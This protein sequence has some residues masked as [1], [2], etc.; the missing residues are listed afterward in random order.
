MMS[1]YK[2]HLMKDLNTWFK[3]L[4][5]LA[6]T[7]DNDSS[8]PK[9]ELLLTNGRSIS[10]IIVESQQRKKSHLLMIAN[11]T[12]HY[13]EPNITIIKSSQIAGLTFIEPQ[14][15]PRLFTSNNVD[16]TQLTG[17]LQFKR[18]VKDAAEE[19]NNIIP[20]PI[21][22]L[23][24][25]DSYLET[26]RHIVLNSLKLIPAVFKEL[27]ADELGKSLV[28]E[29]IKTIKISIGSANTATLNDQNLELIIKNTSFISSSEET[30]RIKTAIENLL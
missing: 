19:L 12:N 28:S 13:S 29:K 18:G 2:K 8:L 14:N 30:E 17:S 22:L 21:N 27:T 6:R 4:T 11:Y 23:I 1:D 5:D 10:G 3:D 24:D 26:E 20:T 25:I 16:E 9:L 15:Y 7:T